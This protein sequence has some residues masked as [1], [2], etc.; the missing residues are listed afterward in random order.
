MAL[1]DY[2]RPLVLV[3]LFGYLGRVLMVSDDNWTVVVGNLRNSW[4]WWVRM[5][6]IPGWE[7]ADPRTSGN[8]Y[9]PVVQSTLLFGA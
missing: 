7:E 8:L 6:R 3:P 1:Q 2:R 5:S 4:K 9:K